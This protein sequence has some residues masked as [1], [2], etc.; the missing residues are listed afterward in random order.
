ML[1]LC[2]A[3]AG[4]APAAATRADAA[5]ATFTVPSDPPATASMR[6]ERDPVTGTLTPAGPTADRSLLPL[7]AT[8]MRPALERL[9]PTRLDDGSLMLDLSGIYLDFA[10]ARLDWSGHPVLEDSRLDYVPDVLRPLAVP[11]PIVTTWAEE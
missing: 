1:A 4:A 9:T 6:V 7:W 3:G 2:T 5:S 8:T 10:T 11:A